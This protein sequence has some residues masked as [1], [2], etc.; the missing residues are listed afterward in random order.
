MYEQPEP[1]TRCFCRLIITLSMSNVSFSY[2]VIRRGAIS[3]DPDF[4]R[5]DMVLRTM[6]REAAVVM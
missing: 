5:R 4:E 1:Y 3:A 2:T 6:L